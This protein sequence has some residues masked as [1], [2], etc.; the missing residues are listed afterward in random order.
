MKYEFRITVKTPEHTEHVHNDVIEANTYPEAVLRGY[1]RT[2]EDIAKFR[3]DNGMEKLVI[4]DVHMY[5]KQ[6]TGE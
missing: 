4:L 5:A 6:V 2:L 1:T 3:R